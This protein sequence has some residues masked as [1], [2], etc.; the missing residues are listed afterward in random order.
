MLTSITS[1]V[2]KSALRSSGHFNSTV[3]F[4]FATTSPHVKFFQPQ[5]N[6]G[7]KLYMS[8]LQ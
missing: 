2:E 4:Y 1:I 8:D 3:L 6:T 7:P 5:N